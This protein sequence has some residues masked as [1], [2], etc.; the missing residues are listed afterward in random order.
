MIVMSSAAAVRAIMDKRG[1]DTGGRPR[2]LVQGAFEGLH[3]VLEDMGKH[4]TNYLM[5]FR[6]Q[7]RSCL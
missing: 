6:I 4:C 3:M 7:S 5:S 1:A 2:S